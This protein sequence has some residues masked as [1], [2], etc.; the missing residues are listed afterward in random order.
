MVGRPPEAAAATAQPPSRDATPTDE[1]APPVEDLSSAAWPDD[2][3]ESS[4]LA[5]ARERGEVVVPKKAEDAT[6]EAETSPMPP[7]NELV[8][9]I[10]AEVRE[11]LDDLFRARFVTVK[12]VPK[13]ALKN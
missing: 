1:G 2:A 10:P 8:E 7:L 5:E 6:E 13:R 3:A 9:R 12:R 11:V 4:F